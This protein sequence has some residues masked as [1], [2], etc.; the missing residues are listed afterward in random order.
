MASTVNQQ[1]ITLY[2]VRV[3]EKGNQV[4]E[5]IETFLAQNVPAGKLDAEI[6]NRIERPSLDME[7]K[8]KMPDYYAITDNA[9]TIQLGY[10]YAKISSTVRWETAGTRTYITD[11]YYFIRKIERISNSV[12]KLTLRLD[13]LNTYFRLPK[14]YPAQGSRYPQP[15]IWG[16]ISGASKI[17]RRHKD[18]L[19]KTSGSGIEGRYPIA[20]DRFN[21]GFDPHLLVDGSPEEFEAPKVANETG[22][23]MVFYTPDGYSQPYP[24]FYPVGDTI[25]FKWKKMHVNDEGKVSFTTESASFTDYKNVNISDSKIF[26]VF[27]LPCL[28]FTF[29]E[30]WLANSLGTTPLYFEDSEIE[31]LMPAGEYL[32]DDSTGATKIFN[33]G[34]YAPMV[35]GGN[36]SQYKSSKG[37][38][39]VPPMNV[40]SLVD[41]KILWPT[42]NNLREAFTIDF[43]PQITSFSNRVSGLQI[44]IDTPSLADGRKIKDTKVRYGEFAHYSLV[45]DSDELVINL[46]QFDYNGN[47]GKNT[48][49]CAVRLSFTVS[50]QWSG[51]SYYQII[52]WEGRAETSDYR[53]TRFS[54]P[55]GNILQISRSNED[56]Q[57]DSAYLDYMRTGY[58]YDQKA[59]NLSL[60]QG[61]VN[62]GINIGGTIG[63]NLV[64]NVFGTVGGIVGTAQSLSGTA[65]NAIQSQ[66]E[67]DR[68]KA[69]ASAKGSSVSGL[70]ANDLFRKYNG[71]RLPRLF[72]YKTPDYIEDMVD[73]YFY[74][75]GYADNTLLSQYGNFD[76]FRN[77]EL[78]S[79]AWF[80][81]IEME[82]VWTP[83]INFT[84]PDEDILEEVKNKFREGVTFFHYHA[85]SS[86][87]VDDWDFDRKRENYERWLL[88]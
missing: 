63:A 54:S 73:N 74:F 19:E 33:L 83:S 68:R 34:I 56:P 48:G 50:L 37:L 43:S 7:V 32:V 11:Y 9:P 35:F 25:S 60:I 51:Q 58:N 70:N 55:Y 47:T 5:D 80:N 42:A 41:E 26:K 45:L 30:N 3:P 81:Y 62:T 66:M 17:K 52:D 69:E 16:A 85:M 29:V 1:K 76:D 36:P 4:I 15:H 61:M 87:T 75:Y 77:D 49:G 71:G 46:D 86:S 14:E 65:F 88:E 64:G 57:G 23:K 2:N 59:R 72:H 78:M 13:V 6:L 82:I 31:Y 12:A 67:I 84:L 39:V 18:R 40:P 79:R 27:D 38:A 44:D 22:W 20:I 10:R 28:P 53:L 24:I 21:E 8:V